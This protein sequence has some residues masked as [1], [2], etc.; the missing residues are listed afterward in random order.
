MQI[1]KPLSRSHSQKN[2]PHVQS[3]QLRGLSHYRILC[4]CEPE[5]Y[6]MQGIAVTL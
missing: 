2:N 3:K 5:Q 6:H 4:T 1:D